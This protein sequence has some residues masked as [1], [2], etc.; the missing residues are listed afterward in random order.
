M[1]CRT[2]FS[3][4]DKNKESGVKDKQSRPVGS[5]V[6][7]EFNNRYME[8]KEY[9]QYR[10]RLVFTLFSF[11]IKISEK[12]MNIFHL[13][14]KSV[15]LYTQFLNYFQIFLVFIFWLCI[16]MLFLC[17][18]IPCFVNRVRMRGCSTVV[19]RIMKGRLLTLLW[20][21]RQTTMLPS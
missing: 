16:F 7:E 11:N 9:N 10:N 4:Y 15:N 13:I 2:V 21:T 1:V 17:F 6:K 5:H 8:N 3:R 20:R 12:N 18:K 19:T 14:K